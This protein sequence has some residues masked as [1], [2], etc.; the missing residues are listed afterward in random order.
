[1]FPNEIRDIIAND[2]RKLLV[3]KDKYLPKVISLF[4]KARSFPVWYVDDYVIPDTRNEHITFYYASNP[5]EIFHPKCLF[6]SIVS[7]DDQRYVIRSLEMEYKK[8]PD[9]KPIVLP[10]IHSYTSHF[11]KRYNERFLHK[12]GITADEI[13][14]LFLINNGLPLIIK[15]N[16]DIKM[17]F[18]KYGEFNTHGIKADGGF[19]FASMGVFHDKTK[20]D[21]KESM[22]I[23]YNTFVSNNE[24]SDIQKKAIDE[25]CNETLMRHYSEFIEKV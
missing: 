24:M 21:E 1:M 19:C 17:N 6:L 16:E 12:N 7:D 3:R 8:T 10:Q 14:G 25:V 2:K 13:A 9:S 22:L 4:K 5:S 23:K 15:L 18:E 20:V 11:L